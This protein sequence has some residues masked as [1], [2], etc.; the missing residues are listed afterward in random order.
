M[1]GPGSGTSPTDS[2]VTPSTSDTTTTTR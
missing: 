1:G 2:T